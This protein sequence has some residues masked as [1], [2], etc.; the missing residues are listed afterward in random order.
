[1]KLKMIKS[2]NIINKSLIK[3][4]TKIYNKIK[5][6][7]STDDYVFMKNKSIW[8]N[9]IILTNKYDFI[10]S[11]IDKYFNLKYYN[12]DDI[13]TFID[14]SM[15]EPEYNL[16][17][18]SIFLDKYK[19]KSENKTIPDYLF[20][21]SIILNTNI[22]VLNLLIEKG[23]DIN[24]INWDNLTVLMYCARINN[25]N[26][27]ILLKYLIDK[28]ANLNLKDNKG[29]TALMHAIIKSNKNAVKLL[30]KNGADI[31]I[32]DFRENT[33]LILASKYSKSNNYIFKFLLKYNIDINAKNKYGYSA[34]SYTVGTNIK[35]INLELFDIL[36]NKGADYNITD[37]NGFNLMMQS[38]KSPYE[39]NRLDVF[40][41]LHELGNNINHKSI[42]GLTPI[43]LALQHEIY[44]DYNDI[45]EIIK[46]LIDNNA[47]LED[48]T[49]YGFNIYNFTSNKKTIENFVNLKLF[50][51]DEIFS[52]ANLI[53]TECLICTDNVNCIQCK[54]NHQICIKCIRKCNK[55]ECPYC[56]SELI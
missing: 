7:I 5:N 29:R 6:K 2:E 48:K 36:I 16:E 19:K 15:S 8:L 53:K 4:E 45:D 34:L 56:F 54:F 9:L 50:K 23:A 39:G 3:Y 22:E 47:N 32:K 12:C 52:N 1:M 38:I 40:K 43:M 20:Y 46:F 42:E 37:K 51:L 55:I 10:N 27:F 11:F 31:S 33:L 41:K 13:E 21:D 17:T 28:G 24:K 26:Q 14:L 30:I 35:N 44:S 25:K 49:T 18:I